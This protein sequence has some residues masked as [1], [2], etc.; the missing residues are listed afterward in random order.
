MK[1]NRKVYWILFL[2]LSFGVIGLPAWSG[3]ASF[4]ES[5]TPEELEQELQHLLST[6]MAQS[7]DPA[8]LRCLASL[9][10]DLGYGLYVDHAKKLVSFQEGARLAKKS[11]EYE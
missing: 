5:E 2:G 11:L 10:L 1:S 6:G 3:E 7:Q 9:Y 4:I 8:V